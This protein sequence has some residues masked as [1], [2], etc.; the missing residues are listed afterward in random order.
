MVRLWV[1]E[2]AR[3][4]ADRLN[5]ENDVG[6]L[7][8]SIYMTTRENLK[9]D[10]FVCFKTYFPENA[11]SDIQAMTRSAVMMTEVIKFSDLLDSDKK[12][13]VRGYDELAHE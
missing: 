1:H 13:A 9:E 5:D 8:D 3:V 4:F 11:G 10:L 12:Q 2:I 7:F 6:K